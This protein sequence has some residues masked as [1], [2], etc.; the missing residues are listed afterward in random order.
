V[1]II[2]TTIRLQKQQITAPSKTQHACMYRDEEEGGG[3]C[4]LSIATS[5]TS[6]KQ[7]AETGDSEKIR[8]TDT[9]LQRNTSK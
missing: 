8:R 9:D 3:I 7:R 4:C 6:L 2:T 1:P 5:L